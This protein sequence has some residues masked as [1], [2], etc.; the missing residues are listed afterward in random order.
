VDSA[1]FAS[2]DNSFLDRAR[3]LVAQHRY[4]LAETELGGALEQ[5][6]GS[7]AAHELMAVCR[8]ER[9]DTRAAHQ[10]ARRAIELLPSWPQAYTR[11]AWTILRDP[12]FVPP[13]TNLWRI[14]NRSPANDPRIREIMR[15]L[16]EALRLD[17]QFAYAWTLLACAWLEAG[18]ADNALG[19]AEKGLSLAPHDVELHNLRAFALSQLGRTSEAAAATR[20]ALRLNPEHAG[21]FSSRGQVL[22]QA[23]KLREA[24][25]SFVE[26][27]RLDP[28]DAQKRAA[29]FAAMQTQH[30]IF[31][32]A[33]RL[34]APLASM[35]RINP[36]WM[37]QGTIIA[38]FAAQGIVNALTAVRERREAGGRGVMIVIVGV[39]LLLAWLRC[40]AGY[41][42][43]F[44]ARARH[45]VTPQQRATS[46][47]LTY[48]LPLLMLAVPLVALGVPG[49]LVVVA[50]MATGPLGVAT[51][52]ARGPLRDA[53]LWYAALF[54][55]L[56]CGLAV[57]F[58]D[59][60]HPLSNLLFYAGVAGAIGPFVALERLS[61]RR[62]LA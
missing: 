16:K 47:A 33:Y 58:P 44:H 37:I 18:R 13:K 54:V 32:W 39:P 23:G 20:E 43:T 15:L 35:W 61:R 11:H 36:I 26:A 28:T 59:P 2:F 8:L 50:L 52:Q 29:L 42:L 27:V 40:L 49:G 3:V 57:V 41:V 21:A 9:G 6:P 17:P 31:R 51:S 53:F 25:E 45:L 55:A 19:A 4:D 24:T 22:M 34:H 46:H 7:P 14:V 12:R 1:H 48:L 38:V 5:V 10:F 56:A 30:P 62:I 60:P